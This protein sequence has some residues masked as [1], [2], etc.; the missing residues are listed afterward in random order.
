MK[1]VIDIL[2]RYWVEV[3]CGAGAVLGL[4]LIFLGLGTMSE[5][6]KELE[7]AM[8]IKSSIA[9][10]TRGEVIN[11]RAVD[12]SARIIAGVRSDYAKVMAYV[13]ERNL[14]PPLVADVFPGDG[15]VNLAKAMEFRR[16]FSE[17]PGKWLTQLNAGAE[18]TAAEIAAER[19]LMEAQ[20]KTQE[21]TDWGGLGAPPADTKDTPAKGLSPEQGAA[22]RNAR[23]KFIY[24]TP[25]SF[26][27][28]D[29]SAPGG[30]MESGPPP[31]VEQ[32]WHAQLEAWIQQ[33]VV[34]AITH[35]NAGVADE[36]S[37]RGVAPW[38]G[39]LPIKDLLSLQTS[40]YYI[41]EGMT[42]EGA[43]GQT[44][45][46]AF[47]PVGPTDV[48][49]ERQSNEQYEVLRFTVMMVVDAR[50]MPRVLAGLCD[51]RFH[52]PLNVNY[53][54]IE[55]NLDMT[56]KIYGDAPVVLLT[57]DF[58]TVM[59][60]ELYLPLMPQDVLNTLGKTRPEP[61]AEGT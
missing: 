37:A 33:T 9:G 60:S 4:V 27:E 5:V 20:G 44:K 52:V 19:D 59:F 61:P 32:M 6:N 16:A 43:G 14:Y 58:E 29:V 22:I 23:S 21:D 26:T 45:D 31:T 2:K 34:D 51:G 39:N 36:L 38:V 18:P 46:R 50:E 47:P 3:A 1:S 56:G 7:A 40:R 30:P 17:L 35:I 13:K 41:K 42:T 12:Q 25:E 10:L 8:R 11:Q 48:F 24:A 53:Q 49:T 15:G 54:A 57:A 55:P 28:S